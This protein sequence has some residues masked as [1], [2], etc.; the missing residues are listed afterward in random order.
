MDFSNIF[1]KVKELQESMKAAQARISKLSSEG[2]A[3]G[4]MVRAKVNGDRRVI[5]IQVD[6][7]L[8]NNEDKELIQDLSV[9]AVN[10]ALDKMD[11]LTKE[12]MKSVT[13]GLPNIPGFS[14]PGFES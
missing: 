3:G 14:F 7:A 6:D 5:E 10:N 8:V 9:A 2:E 11:A 4:G 13:G 1:G 12:E